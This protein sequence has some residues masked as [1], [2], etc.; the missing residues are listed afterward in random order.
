MNNEELKSNLL[1]SRHWLRLVFMLLFAAILQIA[2][3]IMWAL[4][5]LQF[6]FSLVTGQDNT[7]LRQFG[8]SLSTYIFQILK[9]LTYASD[10]KPFPFSDWPKVSGTIIVEDS[11]AERTR[12]RAAKVKTVVKKPEADHDINPAP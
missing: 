10:E 6:L 4:V 9:F 12:T 7:N 5:L 2:S 1:S 8:H 3:I 11:A